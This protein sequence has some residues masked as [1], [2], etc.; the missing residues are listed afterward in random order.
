MSLTIDRSD[1]SRGTPHF[2]SDARMTSHKKN[3]IK[4]Y[5]KT[6]RKPRTLY[7]DMGEIRP[8]LQT[9]DVKM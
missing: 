3:P 7:L 6:C 1:G 9:L 4:Y 2:L 5:S 8:E